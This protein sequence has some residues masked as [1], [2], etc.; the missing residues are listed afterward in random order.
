[1]G[2]DDLDYYQR[3]AEQETSLASAA[4]E[5]RVVAAHYALAELYLERVAQKLAAD[6]LPRK[7][8]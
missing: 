3:R 8:G 6:P 4:T 2:E 7:A 1:M 5:P